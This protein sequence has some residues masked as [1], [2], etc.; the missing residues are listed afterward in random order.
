MNKLLVVSAL[1]LFAGLLLLISKA[2][3]E[4][5]NVLFPISKKY[6][7]F[8]FKVSCFSDATEKQCA[9]SAPNEK[10][11]GLFCKTKKCSSVKKI[12]F[13]AQLPSETL[14]ALAKDIHGET[15]SIKM[16]EPVFGLYEIEGISLYL[17]FELF[18][19]RIEGSYETQ[20][21]GG[22]DVLNNPRNE[23]WLIAQRNE[24]PRRICDEEDQQKLD[25]FI[26]RLTQNQS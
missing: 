8:Y 17:S 10:L 5:E 3:S 14:V 12:E 20:A 18:A 21:F 24:P 7:V 16:C 19:A 2:P 26:H 25:A 22:F 15:F 1:A 13:Y 4:N 6:D 11:V 23:N 9:F